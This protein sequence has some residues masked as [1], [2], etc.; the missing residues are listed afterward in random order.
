M[1]NRFI[2][3]APSSYTANNP[4][5]L[6]GIIKTML[7]HP[8]INIEVSDEQIYMCIQKTMELFG[9]YHFSGSNKAYHVIVINSEEATN[10][11]FD[12][13]NRGIYS[14]S[15]IVRT[16][17]NVRAALQKDSS[18]LWVWDIVKGFA[19]PGYNCG[20]SNRGANI[21]GGDLGYLEQVMQRQK[22]LEE[23]IDP[24]PDYWYND[25]TG[26][27]RVFNS[28]N[29]GDF[30]VIET[31]TKGFVDVGQALG[32]NTAG[33][34]VTGVDSTQHSIAD[35]YQNPGLGAHSV[36]VAGGRSERPHGSYNNRWVK[37]YSTE[38]V[39]YTW[40]NILA[41]HQGMF[42]AG[43]TTIDGMRMMDQAQMN[44]D[45]LREEV[46]EHDMPILLMG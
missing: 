13:S 24:L 31:W 45:K 34:A 7:G 42:S 19:T 4:T 26:Q 44:M 1:N 40:G 10:G 3:N 36:P 12:L 43:G 39:K 17:M 21:F 14:V 6:L 18:A 23:Y 37:E 28:F 9:E 46:E 38:M 25:S 5:E 41:K 15:K 16:G 8:V 2:H 32:S 22:M 33:Q 20:M 30:I 29:I 35:I 11:V 27:L